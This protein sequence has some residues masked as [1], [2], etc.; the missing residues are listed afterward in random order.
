MDGVSAPLWTRGDARKRG[1]RYISIVH[2]QPETLCR[3]AVVGCARCR[4][5][6]G[7]GRRLRRTHDAVGK[8]LAERKPLV[9]DSIKACRAGWV[10]V[11][12]GVS[13]LEVAAH[14]GQVIL[15]IHRPIL[16]HGHA[17]NFLAA[18][19]PCSLDLMRRL[20]GS[21]PILYGVQHLVDPVQPL[22]R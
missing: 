11:F 4:L 13:G 6:H 18:L 5:I 10:R 3:E 16:T 20:N 1:V 7:G 15:E 8:S 21:H 2:D 14:A 19:I 9:A 12:G 17:G 22:H